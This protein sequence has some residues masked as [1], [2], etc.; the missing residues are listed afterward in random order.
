MAEARSALHIFAWLDILFTLFHG[1]TYIVLMPDTWW[2]PLFHV[3]HVWSWSFAL[4]CSD[5]RNGSTTLNF[6][7]IV[8][9]LAAF[10]DTA[11]IFTRFFV[12]IWTATTTPVSQ[13]IMWG[14]SFVLV[15]VAA[16]EIMWAQEVL[17]GLARHDAKARQAYGTQAQMAAI[18]QA[19]LM[20]SVGL[21]QAKRQDQIVSQAIANGGASYTVLSNTPA[22]DVFTKMGVNSAAAAILNN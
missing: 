21:G 9:L 8:F 5:A 3:F 2:M 15:I 14:Q 22:A 10:V 18:G 1:L 13:L 11:G 19:T 17:T 16:L 12:Q 7:F 4:G 6:G 20:A